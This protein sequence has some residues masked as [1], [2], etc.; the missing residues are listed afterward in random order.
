MAE[1]WYNHKTGEVEEGP[2]SLGSDRDG[3]F[4]TREEA[5]RAPQIAQERARAW[6]EEDAADR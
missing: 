6:A 1:Y 4:A 3:P 5:A 2:Q